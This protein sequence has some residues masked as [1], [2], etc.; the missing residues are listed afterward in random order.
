MGT[1]LDEFAVH[2]TPRRRD[3]YQQPAS[4]SAN[5]D[6]RRVPHHH[7][8]RAKIRAV[9]FEHQK[10]CKPRKRACGQSR[11]RWIHREPSPQH[12]P[13]A[14]A[15]GNRNR[16]PG[17]QTTDSLRPQAWEK[18]TLPIITEKPAGIY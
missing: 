9:D 14:G 12:Q 1:M 5:R 18:V 4:N 15:R 2:S 16:Q 10:L 13:S 11:S 6:H 7:V 17:E 8:Q 3:F